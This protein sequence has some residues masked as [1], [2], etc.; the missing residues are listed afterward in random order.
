MNAE[1]DT[2]QKVILITG[3]G[4]GIG[5]AIAEALA[6]SGSTVVVAGRRED[7]LNE[8]VTRIEAKGGQAWARSFDVRDADAVESA[9]DA[10]VERYGRIDGL[11]NNA[12]GN[13]V[14]RAEEL[15]PKGWRAV[16]DIVLNGSWNCT[17]AVA[18]KM[19][20]AHAPGSILSVIATYAWTGHPG[21][22]H[23]AAAKAGVLAMTKTL[24]VEWAQYGIRL[25][26]IAP[27][28]TLTAGAGAALW[29]TQEEYESVASSVPMGRFAEPYEIA[30]LAEVLMGDLSGYVTGEVLTVDGGQVLGKQIYG[31][32]LSLA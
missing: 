19:I 26:C 20:A 7:V 22:V 1:P 4:G 25:N 24:A 15:S 16:V 29:S 6:D 14:C 3:G 27:G 30:R 18:R 21:T 17:S 32:P 2:D 31:Q 10:I 23:S 5:T 13:F 9:V 12:A 11:V 28:P 8:V